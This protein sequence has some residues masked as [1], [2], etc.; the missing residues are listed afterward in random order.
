S[1]L[2]AE[3]SKVSSQDRTRHEKGTCQNGTCT[4]E[5]AVFARNKV[6]RS[7]LR[8]RSRTHRSER[9]S[10]ARRR[11][12][13]DQDNSGKLSKSTSSSTIWVGIRASDYSVPQ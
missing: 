9:Q 12:V 6:W 5:L 7:N 10:S 11:Q 3:T 8:F 13:P 2:N 1:L 4:I